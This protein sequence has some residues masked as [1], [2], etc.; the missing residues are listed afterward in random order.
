MVSLS[1]FNPINVNLIYGNFPVFFL[2]SPLVG[3][4]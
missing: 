3:I 4:I 2:N 1:H